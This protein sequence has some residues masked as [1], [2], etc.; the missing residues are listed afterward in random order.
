MKYRFILFLMMAVNFY[1]HAQLIPRPLPNST[2]VGFY[3]FRPADY[4]TG[5]T[6]KHPVIICLGGQGEDGDGSLAQLSKLLISAV[7]YMINNGATMRFTWEG[8]TQSFVVLIPQKAGGAWSSGTIDAM[9]NYAQNDPLLDMNRVFVT[10][11]SLG[12]AGAWNYASSIA[13]GSSRIAGIVPVAPS[14]FSTSCNIAQNR[15]AVWGIH[16]SQDASPT[17]PGNTIAGVQTL[18]NCAGILVRA[19]QSI[20]NNGAHDPTVF[21]FRSADT[22]NNL[23]YPNIYQWMMKISRSLNPATNLPPVANAGADM[24]LDVPVRDRDII[25]DGRSSSDPDDIISEFKWER[26][27][28]TP[29]A[30]PVTFIAGNNF[31][32]YILGTQTVSYFPRIGIVKGN[33]DNDKGFLEPGIYT[34]RLSVTDY[35]GTVRTDDKV[36]T[37][38][39]PLVGNAKPGVYFVS[40]YIVQEN[41]TTQRIQAEV[42]DWDGS[43]QNYTWN[44][45]RGPQPVTFSVNQF[46]NDLSNINAAG[47]Y[48]FELIVTDNGGAVS[49]DT[50]LVTKLGAAVLPVTLSYFKGKNAASKNILNWATTDE[51]D[52][53][54]FEIERSEDGVNFYIIGSIA[55][56]GNGAGVTEYS[57]EDANALKGVNY[58]RLRQVDKNGKSTLSAVITVTVSNKLVL[59]EHYP[60]PV[61]DLLTLRVEGNVF[62]NIRVLITD[63]QGRAVSQKTIRKDGA[64]LQNSI[65][66]RQLQSGVYQLELLFAD[67]KKEVRSFVKN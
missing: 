36:I 9:I 10:G 31:S 27:P 62:G 49:K 22:T 37:V 42:K 3:E 26:L 48:E 16:G 60:N 57:F 54:R 66:V 39:L 64:L 52:N 45:L 29:P 34:F 63:I 2:G 47:V 25:L 17:D 51:A 40:D 30:T 21:T 33:T 38:R 61:H 23:H 56:K 11:Y 32:F 59:V 20:Y 4:N 43:I 67:G 46:I 14:G 1:A 41:A 15:I 28:V 12:G 7:P 44:Q 19:K 65:E 5:E 58:Y 55:G 35:K 50:V 24:V 6:Y 8:V 13:P 53:D 18:N